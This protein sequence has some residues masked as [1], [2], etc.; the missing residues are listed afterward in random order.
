MSIRRLSQELDELI[1]MMDNNS[2]YVVTIFNIMDEEYIQI[3]SKKFNSFKEASDYKNEKDR[4]D[5]FI[6]IS[7]LNSLEEAVNTQDKIIF[8]LIRDEYGYYLSESENKYQIYPFDG[9][10]DNINEAIKDFLE[11]EYMYCLDKDISASSIKWLDYDN[12]D[13]VGEIEVTLFY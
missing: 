5:R 2:C 13:C 12:I 3:D 9:T 7:K 1:D 8:N 4:I 11:Y 10:K 6:Q